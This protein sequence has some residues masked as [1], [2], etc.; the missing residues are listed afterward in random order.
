MKEKKIISKEVEEK[1][2]CEVIN[3]ITKE[4][5]TITN[6]KEVMMKIYS[7]MEKNAKIDK[8]YLTK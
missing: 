5:M 4:G 8:D 1:F 3:F 2:I 6:T 7:Y